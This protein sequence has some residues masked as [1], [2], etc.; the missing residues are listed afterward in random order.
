MG[1]PRA[2]R[3]VYDT[4]RN[5]G[6]FPSPARPTPHSG[7]RRRRPGT[8][9]RCS[10]AVCGLVGWL[11]PP[12]SDPAEMDAAVDRMAATLVHR[13]PDDAGRWTDAAAGVAL[14]FRRL[15]ILDL[16]PAGHQPML[17]ADGRY[18]CVFNGEIY[19]HRDLRAELEGR[20]ARFRGT[21]DTEVIVEAAAAWGAEATVGRLWGMFALALWDRVERR[22]LLARDRLG[23]KP[24][25][26]ARLGEAG[27][28]FGSELKA[29][30][31]VEGF[32]RE[33]D[34]RAVASF[35]RYGYVPSPLAIFRDT[36]KLE[37]GTYSELRFGEPVRTERYWDPRA[38]A[39]AGLAARRDEP[40]EV[41][42]SELDA[43][44]RDAVSRRMISDVP[45]G[46][47]L[48]GGI[49]SSAVVAL[50]Q[51]QSTRPV[52]TFS[53]G[54]HHDEYNEA[55]AAAAVAGHLGTEHT[56]LYVSSDEARAVIPELPGI[57]DEPFADSSQIPTLLIARLA[58]QYV[59]V[60][61]SGDGGDETFAGYTRY[62]ET[63]SEWAALASVPGLVRRPLRAVLAAVPVTWWDGAFALVRPALPAW[64]R[65]RWFSN[66]VRTSAAMLRAADSRD[67]L[68]WRLLSQWS[69]PE[70]LFAGGGAGRV[71]LESADLQEELPDFR[72]RMTLY[73]LAT[74][75]PDDILV[76][77]DRASMA[78]S[79]ELRSP[80]L[81]HRVIEWA[82][83]LPFALKV[84]ANA[85][86][87]IL[88]QVLYRYVPAAL[89]D[90]PKT[91]FGVPLGHW[92]RGPLREWAE[93]ILRRD[94]L[95][96]AGLRPNPVLDRWRRHLAGPDDHYRL[97]VVLM[98]MAWWERWAS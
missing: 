22:L 74:Y 39:R 90:R 89:V 16:S 25:Y 44:L 98:F 43:L 8:G 86:K 77:T 60:G 51:A 80:L 42:V 83:T 63:Q 85:T 69:D 3:G 12:G 20:G 71:A 1:G 24:L 29:F 26:V 33:I 48:S 59:T 57:Y 75:L 76:K 41:L 93:S 56:E 30:H 79:L 50:M 61:L 97:W 82:W 92:L 11:A 84:H 81:D 32:R 68:Y 66:R 54:F 35:L 64:I 38:V 14:G 67:A 95:E 47:F 46:A 18:A 73:D 28:L 19:N 36:W 72:E 34:P 55:R 96:A 62:Q 94:R 13:G 5:R 37:P 6:R 40:A 65:Q 17:S 87:W 27:W 23:K 49:D 2:T 21:S 10:V 31:A 88:R 53:V 4:R 58:R 78:A 15:S 9:A 45:L 70:L 52:R 7:A 91:G